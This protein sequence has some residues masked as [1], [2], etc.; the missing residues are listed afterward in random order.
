MVSGGR[1][2][3]AGLELQEVRREV[4]GVVPGKDWA[5]RGQEEE[6][7]SLPFFQSLVRKTLQWFSITSQMPPWGLPAVHHLHSIPC[8]LLHLP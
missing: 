6:G 1:G 8:H 5:G 7:F 2:R 3:E 4:E